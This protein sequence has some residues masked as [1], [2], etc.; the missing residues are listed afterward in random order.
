MSNNTALKLQAVGN[1]GTV[2][3]KVQRL[4]VDKDGKVFSKKVLHKPAT[5]D[6]GGNLS[7][8]VY[9]EIPHTEGSYF[10]IGKDYERVVEVKS[11][12]GNW[13]YRTCDGQRGFTLVDEVLVPARSDLKVGSLKITPEMVSAVPSMPSQSSA[14]SDSLDKDSISKL[15]LEL[16]DAYGTIDKYEKRELILEEQMSTHPAKKKLTKALGEIGNLEAKVSHASQRA[17]VAEE[18]LESV[19]GELAILKSADSVDDAPAGSVL[20]KEFESSLEEVKVLL[21]QSKSLA[22]DPSSL[23]MIDKLIIGLSL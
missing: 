11:D 6:S 23:K 2:R 1:P 14:S 7:P 3:R 16:D 22:K 15:E 21:V 10:L 12:S 9:E 4:D 5:T 17:S 13:F 20:S 18:E 8:K 19:L